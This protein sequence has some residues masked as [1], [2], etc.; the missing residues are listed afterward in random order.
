M[1]YKILRLHE[2][3]HSIAYHIQV[4]RTDHSPVFS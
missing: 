3:R 1:D 2:F 4:Y